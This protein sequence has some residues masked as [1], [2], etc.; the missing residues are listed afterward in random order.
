MVDILWTGRGKSSDSAPEAGQEDQGKG[1]K[2][3]ARVLE[4]V[5]FE[6]KKREPI[7][8]SLVANRIKYT[9][10]LPKN[11]AFRCWALLQGGISFPDKVEY[12]GI[13]GTGWES[14]PFSRQPSP[15]LKKWPHRQ[16][17]LEARETT[18]SQARE[19]THPLMHHAMIMLTSRAKSR[20]SEGA[21]ILERRP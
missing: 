8:G 7:H 12:S 3:P 6:H 21:E 1:K 9:L 19:S 11:Q 5:I 2:S 4:R 14:I 20:E 15:A 13:S 18:I 17:M 10:F 16:A